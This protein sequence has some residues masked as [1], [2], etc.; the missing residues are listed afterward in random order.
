MYDEVTVPSPDDALEDTHENPLVPHVGVGDDP[1]PEDN[2][3]PAST[4]TDTPDPS[5]PD[6]HPSKDTDVDSDE[7]YQEGE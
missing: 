6:D 7:A 3:S 1:L 5:L 4:A 2:D